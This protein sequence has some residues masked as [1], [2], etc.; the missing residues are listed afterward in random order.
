MIGPV[1]CPMCGGIINKDLQALCGR[2]ICTSCATAI[3]AAF[4]LLKTQPC[5]RQTIYMRLKD[6][7]CEGLK[8]YDTRLGDLASW[9]VSDEQLNGACDMSKES[10][11]RV[12]FGYV[13]A[14][15][16]NEY[17]RKAPVASSGGNDISSGGKAAA[18]VVKEE[19]ERQGFASQKD[20]EACE[21]A[22]TKERFRNSRASWVEFRA[23][24][25]GVV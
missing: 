17:E 24:W 25:T 14:I 13:F 6:R 16:R 12:S 9:G 20:Y 15:L 19:W 18:P 4:P 7:R 2:A 5:R 10:T 3:A 23:N 8:P 21:F 11:G 22:F 1:Q